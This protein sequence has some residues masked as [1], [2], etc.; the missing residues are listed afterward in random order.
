LLFDAPRLKEL[1]LTNLPRLAELGLDSCPAL[2]QINFNEEAKLVALELTNCGKFRPIWPRLATDLKYI[3]LRGRI[4]FE[5]DEIRAANG[6]RFLWVE[7]S[8]KRS[9]DVLRDLPSLD[10]VRLDGLKVT[11]DLNELV[12]S[13]NQAHGH[14]STLVPQ[15]GNEDS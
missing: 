5:L 11:K 12:R 15:V 13:I 1:D 7:L 8:G 9:W 2:T 14:G 10:G 3:C 6:L 4:G